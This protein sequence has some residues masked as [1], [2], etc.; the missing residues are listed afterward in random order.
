MP[1]PLPN[2][3]D[4]RWQDLVE[5]GR[6]LIPRFA[7]A[8]TDH[9]AHDPGITLMELFAWLTEMAV[10]RLNRISARHQRKF[11]DL[12]GFPP[13]PPQCARTVLCFDPAPGSEC[14]TL[15]AGVEFATADRTG[16]PVG[17]RTLGSLT[18]APAAIGAVQFDAG[19]QTF[20][21]FTRD[22]REGLPVPA[23]GTDP[24]PNQALCL[25]FR[26]L[27]AE[28]PVSLG[29]RFQ[30]PGAD[31]AE[32]Q[33][34]EAEAR[35]QHAL[36]PQAPPVES[37]LAHHS[38]RTL[39]EIRVGGAWVRLLPAG[40]APLAGTVKDDT[41]SFTLDGFVEIVA[42]AGLQPEVLGASAEPLFYLRCRLESGAPDRPPMLLDVAPN[43][44]AAIQS[45]PVWQSFRIASGAALAGAPP[46]PGSTARLT[47]AMG[48][49]REREILSLSFDATTGPDIPVYSYVP[50]AGDRAGEITLALALAGTG[51]G[52]PN[53]AVDLP[54]APADTAGFGLYT[55]H[56]G[57]WRQW[58][59]VA[60]F[61]ARGRADD[62]ALLDPTEG[63]IVFG[64]GERGRPP[65][66]GCLIFVTCRATLAQA[67]NVPAGTVLKPAA[68]P[69]NKTLLAGI[70]EAA[71]AQLVAAGRQA[72]AGGAPAE[73]LASAAGRAVETLHAHERLLE[74]AAGMK[75]DSLD[76]IDR[77]RVRAVRPPTRATNLLDIERL[78]LETPGARIARARAW[79][80]LHPAWPCLHAPGVV[81]VVVVPDAPGPRPVPSQG[82][83][84]AVWRYLYPRRML[85]TRLEV[86]GPRYLEVSVN[87]TVELKAG[88]GAEGAE[89]RIRAALSQYLD[90]R[91]GGPGSMGWP[92]G[93]GVFRSEI[94]QLL[95]NVPGVDHV[96]TLALEGNGNTSPCGDL[97]ACPASLVAAGEHAIAVR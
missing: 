17:F 14:F 81:T 8:W 12:I 82:L 35:A 22:F 85:C 33:R 10:Y 31:A 15:P 21:D 86:V 5:E 36:L 88:A 47:L 39:W 18:V 55:L 11:L 46:Q 38:A 92:F 64:S 53:Q 87:A 28:Q 63:R 52:L 78:A 96:V 6:A 71:R 54:C 57:A 2:L 65:E 24:R 83:L 80:S 43:S 51:T 95:D 7:P 4:R 20:V 19:N 23:F 37:L 74:L 13:S 42:P 89:K 32:R 94:L 93:R 50:P 67:G 27:P 40:P 44:V 60:D 29:F 66:E 49:D 30:G 3:D 16:G 61:D 69:R 97:L 45:V 41:R 70:P 56:S 25:G 58:N 1:V 72:A 34:I 73:D 84:N 9:N 62:V 79:P 68:S 90:P 26:S 75:R 48:G 91:T 76:Q 77:A 59:L